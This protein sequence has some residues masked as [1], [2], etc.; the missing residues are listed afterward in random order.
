MNP[1]DAIWQ[2]LGYL[3]GP[4]LGPGLEGNVKALSQPLW[5]ETRSETGWNFRLGKLC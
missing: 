4:H 3:A 5:L 1:H 2:A